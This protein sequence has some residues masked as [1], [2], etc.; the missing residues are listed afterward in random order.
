MYYLA[1]KNDSHPLND[2][3][4]SRRNSIIGWKLVYCSV[5]NLESSVNRFRIYIFQNRNHFCATCSRQEEGEEKRHNNN[6]KKKDLNLVSITGA[7]KT[8]D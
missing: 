5:G 4:S 6:K 1:T 3:V 7:Q 2:S 8:I